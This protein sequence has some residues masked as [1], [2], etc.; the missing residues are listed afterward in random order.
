[1]KKLTTVLGIVLISLMVFSTSCSSPSSPGDT[2]KAFSY[3][4]EQG[5][6]DEVIS[7][8]ASNEKDLTKED[9][10]KLS[11][12]VA[13]AKENIEEN[14]GI[15]SIE[16]LEET[17]NEDGIN[18]KVKYETTYGDGKTEKV[19]TKLIMLDGSWKVKF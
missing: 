12:L 5:N 6:V 14:G 17:T 11:A 7:I 10:E 16:I 13:S 8:L 9:R 15:K 2:V 1:M 18:A 4:M 3:A 19:E